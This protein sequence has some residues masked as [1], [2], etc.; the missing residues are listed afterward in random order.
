MA[1]RFTAL[2]YQVYSSDN[3]T[4]ALVCFP[5]AQ[6]ESILPFRDKL[7]DALLTISGIKVN[8]AQGYPLPPDSTFRFYAE[9][10][11]KRIEEFLQKKYPSF[12]SRLLNTNEWT[13]FQNEQRLFSEMI[14]V[15]IENSHD[16]PCI[17]VHSRIHSEESM[18]EL[19]QEAAEE[20]EMTLPRNNELGTIEN[21]VTSNQKFGL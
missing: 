1:P 14:D 18:S 8:K 21:I 20:L 12:F 13:S 11:G 10:H 5:L 6:S 7:A 4:D 2:M 16:F 19:L 15:E 3:G 17:V 9:D